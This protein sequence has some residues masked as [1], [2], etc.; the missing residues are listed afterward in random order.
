MLDVAVAA[1]FVLRNVP[2][3]AISD[4]PEFCANGMPSPSTSSTAVALLLNEALLQVTWPLVHVAAP[5][6]TSVQFKLFGFRLLNVSPPLA[7]TDAAV[8]RV[9]EVQSIGPKTVTG[10]VPCNNP[11]EKFSALGAI[12][13]LPLK[14]TVPPLIVTGALVTITI[15]SNRAVPA[16]KLWL[17]LTFIVP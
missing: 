3:F 5:L 1:P 10:I 12:I 15:P 2:S 9:P 4:M 11:D 14:M 13:P 17:P 16:E 6:F 8:A 7:D